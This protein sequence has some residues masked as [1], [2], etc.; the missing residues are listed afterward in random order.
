MS[1]D[2]LFAILKGRRREGL[3]V[4]A[5]LAAGILVAG[6]LLPVQYTARAAVVLNLK[7]SDGLSSIALPG[8]LVSTHVATQMDIV[9]SERVL[10]KAV[11]SMGL[12]RRPQWQGKWQAAAGG[13]KRFEIWAT[14]TIAKKLAVKPSPDSSVLTVSY[15]S[16][17]PA[18][19]AEVANAV[20]RAYMATSLEMR[21]E[22]ARQYSQYFEERAAVLRAALERARAKLLD[23]QR[24]NNL[25]I[26]DEKINLETDRLQELD[27]KLTEAKVAA[28]ESSAHRSRAAGNPDSVREALQDPVVAAL[29]EELVRQEAFFAEQSMRLGANHPQVLEL[30]SRIAVLKQRRGAAIRKTLGSLDVADKVNQTQLQ[31]LEKDVGAQ[32]AHVLDLEARRVEA[33]LLER[34]IAGTQRAYDAV[35]E[36][37]SQA[38]LQSGDNQSEISIL[39]T[40]S[41]PLDRPLFRLA[42]LLVAA[43]GGAAVVSLAFVLA[44]ER[45]DRKLRTAEDIVARLGQHLLVTLPP[46]AGDACS[47]HPLFSLSLRGKG[48][49][50]SLPAQL[51]EASPK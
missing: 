40:A 28:S 21:L 9:Q 2:Q 24:A 1:L 39:G 18:F 51:K 50:P 38:S 31:A 4:F 8:G 32:R 49:I 23:Y 35:L 3:L 46:A 20:V 15:T 19:A 6:L 37:A 22:P 13:K 33:G 34:E 27:A 5:A 47:A 12:E 14:E 45:F 48:H 43:F 42:R 16:S 41:P 10:L 29:S 30:G 7:S 44:R 11:R 26:T 25:V 17:D 36:K